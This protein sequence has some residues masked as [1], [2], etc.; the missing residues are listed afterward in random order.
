MR[1]IQTL[2]DTKILKVW[3]K[4]GPGSFKVCIITSFYIQILDK[5]WDNLI[6]LN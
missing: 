6:V 3:K 4:N 2:F 1:N 5:N